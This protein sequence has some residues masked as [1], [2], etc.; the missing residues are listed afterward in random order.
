MTKNT[1]LLLA[2]ATTILTMGAGCASN[3][4]AD[5][6]QPVQPVATQT[7]TTEV[8]V[9]GDWKTYQD[10][11]YSYTFDYPQSW[12]LMEAIGTDSNKY[13]VTIQ[14]ANKDTIQIV[15]P[16]YGG[17]VNDRE[18]YLK[19][20]AQ[21]GYDKVVIGG[22]FGYY[23]VTKTKGGP[24]L[25]IF[26]VGNKEI[27]LMRYSVSDVAKTPFVDAEKMFKQIIASFT[28]T[29]TAATEKMK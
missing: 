12:N 2:L 19:V 3:N 1:L 10:K 18:S 22:G 13:N 5:Q 26:L 24:V 15:K 25:A 14:H 11:T 7:S 21:G 16:T 23:S 8:F 27:L 9:S 20:L 4:T 28:F 6:A 29:G 17:S